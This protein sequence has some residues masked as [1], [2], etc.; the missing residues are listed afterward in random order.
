MNSKTPPYVTAEPVITTTKIEPGKEEFV[1]MASDA[2]WEMLTNEEV[3]GLVAEWKQKSPKQPKSQVQ[4][5]WS[6]FWP[7]S[8]SPLPVEPPS[9]IPNTWRIADRPGQWEL[10]RDPSQ[11]VYKDENAATHIARNAFGGNQEDLVAGLLM[12]PTP[13]SRRYRSVIR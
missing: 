9:G 12:L 2:L 8:G 13:N 3:V 6:Y 10:H 4:K 1:V 7:S 11:Y 5:L